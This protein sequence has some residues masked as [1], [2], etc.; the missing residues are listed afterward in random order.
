MLGLKNTLIHLKNC[1]PRIKVPLI[2]WLLIMIF[3]LCFY[4]QL[5]VK[6]VCIHIGNDSGHTEETHARFSKYLRL[7]DTEC[8]AQ[9]IDILDSFLD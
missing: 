5:L 4:H 3:Y 1:G 7:L 9:Q 8:N 2:L 6:C